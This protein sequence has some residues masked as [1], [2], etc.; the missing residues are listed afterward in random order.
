MNRQTV[1]TVVRKEAGEVWQIV[2]GIVYTPPVRFQG[3]SVKWYEDKVK[4]N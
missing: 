4:N 2:T 1:K 3:G